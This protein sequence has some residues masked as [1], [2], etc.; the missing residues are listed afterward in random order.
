MAVAVGP[1]DRVLRR[2]RVVV[3]LAVVSHGSR[4][5]SYIL[6]GAETGQPADL[7]GA[8]QVDP[9]RKFDPTLADA[10]TRH[11]AA[12]YS[13]TSSARASSDCGTV[14]PSALAVLR[15][16]TSSNVVGCWT[17]KSG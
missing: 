15:L 11:S 10:R 7:Q 3:L 13:I 2:E 12:A 6:L 8:P 17:G 16:I 4:S 9:N 14:R 1:L 5:L